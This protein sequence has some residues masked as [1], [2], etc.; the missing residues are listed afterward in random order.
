MPSGNRHLR[1]LPKEPL[2][3]VICVTPMT[4]TIG[5]ITYLYDMPGAHVMVANID[6]HLGARIAMAREQLGMSQ[7][8]VA[9]KMG[10]TVDRLAAFELGTARIPALYV[11]R[12]SG[13]L[14]VTPRWLFD[15]LPG[16]DAFDC[17]G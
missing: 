7:A 4:Q 14:D 16:Q 11:A 15:G 12:L 13:A 2:E 17:T 3:F 6:Q 10:L 1:R 5:V 9:T 8:S